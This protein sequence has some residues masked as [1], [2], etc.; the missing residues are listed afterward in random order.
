MERALISFGFAMGQTIAGINQTNRTAA[1]QQPHQ[2]KH[3]V[4]Y[5]VMFF[6]FFAAVCVFFFFFCLFFMLDALIPV[7]TADT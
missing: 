4:V 2:V 7:A 1:H 6:R 3:C 5:V